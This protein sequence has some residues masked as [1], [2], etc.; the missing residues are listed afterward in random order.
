MSLLDEFLS[1]ECTLHV[2]Q[3]LERTLADDSVRRPHFEFDRFELTIEREDGVAV[4]EDIL[5][6]TDAGVQRVQL[7]DFE[8]ALSRCSAS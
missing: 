8:T 3:L 4:L 6:A 2:R 7:A 5:D 1:Q